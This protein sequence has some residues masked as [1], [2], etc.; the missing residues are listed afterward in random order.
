MCG[1]LLPDFPGQG[2]T[3]KGERADRRME[4]PERSWGLIE[5]DRGEI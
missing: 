5:V 1:G 2:V 3:G 4:G